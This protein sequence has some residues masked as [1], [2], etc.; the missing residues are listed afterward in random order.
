MP[1]TDERYPALVERAL[2]LIEERGEPVGADELCRELFGAAGGPWQRLLEQVLAGDRRLLSLEDGRWGISS[3]GSP[4]NAQ[5]GGYPGSG[6]SA[7]GH[8]APVG[9]LA[10]AALNPQHHPLRGYPTLNPSVAP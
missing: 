9:P 4:T 3:L 7:E 10:G 1:A 6:A 2:R 8:A 5:Q